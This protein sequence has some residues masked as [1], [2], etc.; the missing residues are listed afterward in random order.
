MIFDEKRSCQIPHKIE[1]GHCLAVWTA[2]DYEN[3]S[4]TPNITIVKVSS[5]SDSEH[6]VE[7]RFQHQNEKNALLEWYLHVNGD[8]WIH[9]VWHLGPVKLP[10]EVGL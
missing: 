7:I 2:E 10:G 4:V 1:A 8:S 9:R 6:D 3:D 5:I